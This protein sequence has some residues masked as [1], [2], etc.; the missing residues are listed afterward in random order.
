MKSIFIYFFIDILALTS[1]AKSNNPNQFN[2]NV[3]EIEILNNGS[4]K[5]KEELLILITV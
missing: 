5:V 1:H 3:T 4:G 2:F